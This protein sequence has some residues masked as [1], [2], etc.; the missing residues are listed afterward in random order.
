MHDDLM[1]LLALNDA[2]DALDTAKA[3]LSAAKSA[4]KKATQQR[5]EALTARDG[6][7]ADLDAAKAEERALNRKVE[8]YEARR[9][10]ATRALEMGAGDPDAAERQIEQVGQILDDSETAILELMEKQETLTAIRDA[11]QEELDAK[12]RALE[13]AIAAAPAAIAEATAQEAAA[14]TE[15]DEKRTLVRKDM[16]V[17]YERVRQRKRKPVVRLNG[18]TCPACQLMIG[19][20]RVSELKRGVID[21]LMC[22]GCHRIVVLPD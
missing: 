14:S 21:I 12:E 18:R 20:A 3:R 7:Q 9:A 1:C 10:T 22:P 4:V 15:R 17:H 11:K 19:A 8:Q 5:D 6:A 2:D 16:V 13:A